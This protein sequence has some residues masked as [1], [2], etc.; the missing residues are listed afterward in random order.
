MNW[1]TV[2][3]MIEVEVS[4]LATS[5]EDAEREGQVELPRDCQIWSATAVQEEP[6]T[7]MQLRDFIA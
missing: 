3:Y 5:I 7:D 4:V 1:Y 2:T 6:P